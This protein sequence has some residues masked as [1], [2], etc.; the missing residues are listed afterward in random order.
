MSANVDF[1][2]AIFSIYIQGHVVALWMIGTRWICS[3]LSI[4]LVEWV[5]IVILPTY[6]FSVYFCGFFS[7]WISYGARG[8]VSTFLLISFHGVIFPT[9][10][11][12]STNGNCGFVQ[13]SYFFISFFSPGTYYANAY[14]YLS[15]GHWFNIRFS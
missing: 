11:I 13:T 9:L 8:F 3:N 2:Q 5:P 7:L 10:W 15:L 4:S 12:I 6:F 14:Y 1:F